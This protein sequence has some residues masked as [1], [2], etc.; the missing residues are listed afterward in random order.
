LKLAVG[1][2]P[3]WVAFDNVDVFP[4]T[5]TL[6][7]GVDFSSLPA[8][9]QLLVA[10]VVFESAIQQLTQAL[11]CDVAIREVVPTL[12]VEPQL[13]QMSLLLHASDRQSR[14]R[15]AFTDDLC[16]TFVRAVQKS[17]I[18]PVA[19]WGALP[20][21]ATVEFGKTRLTLA[22]LKSL[23]RLDVLLVDQ[24]CG[25]TP[26]SVILNFASSVFIPAQLEGTQVTVTEPAQAAIESGAGNALPT[27][28]PSLA[29]GQQSLDATAIDVVFE[30]GEVSLTL[31]ELR[32]VAAGATIGLIIPA[33]G[34]RVGLRAGGNR[35]G[36]GELASI[37]SRLGVRLLDIN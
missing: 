28:S 12:P 8:E 24:L 33:D 22:E 31:N 20:L 27:E 4:K 2:A 5:S 25:E 29:L 7:G 18:L 26:A 10:E 21:V 32:S 13:W 1:A 16:E 37:G 30:Q 11:D 36:F 15:V 35:L 14:A 23:D 9:L 19:D 17:A 34:K 6:L 3:A